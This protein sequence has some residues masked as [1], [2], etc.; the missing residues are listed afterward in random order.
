MR[1]TTPPPCDGVESTVRPRTSSSS[2]CDREW[3]DTRG[4]RPRTRAGA[5]RP[6]PP[7]HRGRARASRRRPACAR[8]PDRRRC[9]G[10][11]RR[12]GGSP[13][14]SGA[15]TRAARRARSRRAPARSPVRRGSAHSRV[16]KRPWISS[17]PARSPGTATDPSPTWKTWVPESPKSMTSSSISPSP[18]RRNLE[19][20][21]E[22]RRLAGRLV[23]EREAPSGRARERPFGDECGE[24]GCEERVDGIPAVTQDARAGLGRERMTGCDRASHPGRLLRA[25][26]SRCSGTTAARDRPSA[27]VPSSCRT[28]AARRVGACRRARSRRP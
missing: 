12:A 16:A 18:A 4:G 3:G 15:G 11:P 25:S 21:V 20:A 27:V 10:L 6:W 8:A 2:G 7:R 26:L 19:E 22:H 14:G 24:R 1:W 13:R 9:R 28:P 17:R 5:R 23:D